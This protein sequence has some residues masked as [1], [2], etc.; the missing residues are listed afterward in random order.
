[1]KNLL[2]LAI[3]SFSLIGCTQKALQ[4]KKSRDV[5]QIVQHGLFSGRSTKSSSTCLLTAKF[6]E[7][8]SGY[9]ALRI[10]VRNNTNSDITLDPTELRQ[11]VSNDGKWQEGRVYTPKEWKKHLKVNEFMTAFAAGIGSASASY[12][13]G[14]SSTSSYG[15]ASAYGPYGTTNVYGSS[16]S[17]TYDAGQA[18]QT[19]MLANAEAQQTI[20]NSIN[21]NNVIR[22]ELFEAH[23]LSP[24]EIYEG[25]I[26][27]KKERFE[28]LKIEF[29]VGSDLHIFYIEIDK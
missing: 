10:G 13:A 26:Y 4:V 25:T 5:K 19:R 18:A 8:E 17:T 16:Y 11:Y 1:M 7:K 14:Y 27:I 21:S 22:K 3:I 12:N 20:R 23:T 15:S 9:I 24:N 2:L 28:E 6:Y 29:P